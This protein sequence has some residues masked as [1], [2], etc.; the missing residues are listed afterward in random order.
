[1]QSICIFCG[2]SAGRNSAYTGAAFQLGKLLAERNLKF[3]FPDPIWPTFD[4]AEYT[5]CV[6]TDEILDSIL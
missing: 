3:P 5:P 1:M 2:S 4:V 6:R